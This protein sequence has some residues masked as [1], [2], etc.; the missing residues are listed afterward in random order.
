MQ[1]VSPQYH[2]QL[3][4][5]N[6]NTLCDCGSVPSWTGLLLFAAQ[7]TFFQ[8]KEKENGV[9]HCFVSAMA[10]EAVL[11]NIHKLLALFAHKMALLLKGSFF[12]KKKIQIDRFWRGL[13][14]KRSG[15]LAGKTILADTNHAHY[16]GVCV[17]SG[18]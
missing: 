10:V 14:G 8:Q 2:K 13:L 3:L 16:S 15:F 4:G 12:L 18:L 11:S 1:F 5:N 17:I 7:N 9:I 6:N